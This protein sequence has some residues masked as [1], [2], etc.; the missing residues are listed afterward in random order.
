MEGYIYKRHV[1]PTKRGKQN[2]TNIET[3]IKIIKYREYN[4]NM[5][6]SRKDI[7]RNLN[8]TGF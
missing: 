4:L 1:R 7:K 2:E 8:E 6:W 5:Y 3:G